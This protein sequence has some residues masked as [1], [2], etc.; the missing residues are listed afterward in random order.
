MTIPTQATDVSE[1]YAIAHA[2]HYTAKDMRKAFGHYSRII[3][4]HP[5]SS[6]AGDSRT[7]LLIIAN[8]AIASALLGDRD[9]H[10][11]DH[12]SVKVAS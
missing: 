5:D 8:S 11:P 6:E 7:Q 1:R 10:A 3:E 2:A 4:V 9:G 12:T